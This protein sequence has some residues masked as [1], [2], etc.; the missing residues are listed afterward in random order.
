MDITT[1]Q[2]VAILSEHDRS[3]PICFC[4]DPNGLEFYRVKGRGGVLQI[5]FNQLVSREASGRLTVDHSAALG[6]AP[7]TRVGELVDDLRNCGDYAHKR[8]CFSDEALDFIRVQDTGSH[9]N[10]EFTQ[11]VY[12]AKNGSFVVE[13]GA[14]REEFPPG[15]TST[16]EGPRI[17]RGMIA[18]IEQAASQSAEE[19]ATKKKRRKS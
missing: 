13:E 1:A 10:F 4:G 6:S 2:L 5:E 3:K 9:I 11:R 15:K 16:R 18:A 17:G 12:R 7:V 14:V 19:P 8:V